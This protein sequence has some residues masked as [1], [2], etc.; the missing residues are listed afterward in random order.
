MKHHVMYLI[1]F[2]YP[3]STQI[4]NPTHD[5]NS[6]KIYLLLNLLF[7][8]ILDFAIRFKFVSLKY[9]RFWDLILMILKYQSQLY[10]L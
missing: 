3:P 4:T 6:L 7:W 8:F 9:F 10:K 5:I 1:S 2:P